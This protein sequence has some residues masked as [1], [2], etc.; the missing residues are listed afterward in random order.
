MD[1][2]KTKLA[3]Q[4]LYKQE[5]SEEVI[6]IDEDLIKPSQQTINERQRDY[7]ENNVEKLDSN[8]QSRT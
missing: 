4:A 5:S 8:I 6:Q 7:H 3:A 1:K 2:Q